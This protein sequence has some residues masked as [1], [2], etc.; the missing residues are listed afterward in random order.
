MI[1]GRFER[2]ILLL[3]AL[4]AAAATARLGVWQLDRAGA[5]RVQQEQL[6]ARRT[7][8][9]LPGAQLAQGADEAAAQH[10]RN[11]VVSGRWLAGATVYLDNRSMDGQGGFVV[12]TP[13]LL[14][15]GSAVIVQRGWLP[16]DPAD[17]TRV[18]APALPEGIV[19]VSARVAPW[20]SRLAELGGGSGSG[21][22]RQNLDPRPYER[23]VGA[24]LRPLSLVQLDGPMPDGL[25]RN[26]GAPAS[27]IHKHY[28]YAFQW[29]ALAT[30]IVGLYVWFE[31]IRPQRRRP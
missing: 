4:A 16:R 29:F 18:S 1:R 7:L 19:E 8:P 10:H 5:K 13:L 28:G 26:W 20:P 11:A 21:L 30:L 2:V 31:F 23:E 14:A 9:P 17:R 25:R 24:R 3:A 6:D 15:D 22:I 12:I 27:G